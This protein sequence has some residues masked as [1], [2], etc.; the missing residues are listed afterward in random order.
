MIEERSQ[1]T[2]KDDFVLHDLKGERLSTKWLSEL[3]IDITKFTDE[4]KRTGKHIVPY[5]LR[6]YYA[7]QQIYNGVQTS[8]IAKN[9]GITEARLRK[10]YDHAFTRMRVDELLKKKGAKQEAPKLHSAGIGRYDLI[11]LVGKKKEPNPLPSGLV[12]I[13]EY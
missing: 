12:H 2:N 5:S 8:F 9:M 11:G 1:H 7:T 4:Y 6:H 3:Y 13:P 10:S